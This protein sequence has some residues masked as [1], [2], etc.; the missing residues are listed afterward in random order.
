MDENVLSIS[1]ATALA[2]QESAYFSWGVHDITHEIAGTKVNYQKD[3][4]GEPFQ[5]IIFPTRL[6]LI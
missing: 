6:Y 4:K 5:C 3:F 1:N 2:E